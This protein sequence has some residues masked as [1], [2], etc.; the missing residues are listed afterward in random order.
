V[1]PAPP[2]PPAPSVQHDG[3]LT[4]A[5]RF[6]GGPA[7]VQRFLQPGLVRVFTAA[8]GLAASQQVSPGHR[9]RFQLAP[10]R[11]TLITKHSFGCPKTTATVKARRTAHVAV[12]ID[13]TAS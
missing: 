9:F 5:I 10:G 13:C 6:G 7:G 3:I 11:Y 8:G 1:P 2:V 12:R 4:G